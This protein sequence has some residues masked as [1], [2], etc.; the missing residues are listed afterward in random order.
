MPCPPLTLQRTE[1]PS[2]RDGRAPDTGG[3]GFVRIQPIL[4]KRSIS[5]LIATIISC[6]ATSMPRQRCGPKPKPMLVALLSRKM[7]YSP[8]VLEHRRI[9]VGRAEAHVTGSRG[10]HHAFDFGIFHAQARE[11]RVGARQRSDFHC[12]IEQPR[13]SRQ[14]SQKW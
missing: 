11:H 3:L 7:S 2:S 8:V 6:R 10:N 12:L 4:G 14:A 9:V 13:S 1:P 5:P